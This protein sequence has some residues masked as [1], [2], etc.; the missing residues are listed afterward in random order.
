MG[1]KTKNLNRIVATPP[2]RAPVTLRDVHDR[3]TDPRRRT[4]LRQLE[5]V[6][7][8]PLENMP[9][10]IGWID[11]RV[12][13][14]GFDGATAHWASARA[15]R[16]RRNTLRGT[17][18]RHVVAGGT[19]NVPISPLRVRH[20]CVSTAHYHSPIPASRLL[21]H[22]DIESVETYYANFRKTDGGPKS[23]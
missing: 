8:V 10:K 19:S 14:D 4:A 12:P 21:G 23:D 2:A 7:D 5:A 3:E 20:L 15:Y 6:L 13:K 22:A 1:P 16:H 11:A 9:A 17:I 18:R